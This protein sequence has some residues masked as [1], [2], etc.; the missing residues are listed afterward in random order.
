MIA[1]FEASCSALGLRNV[2]IE[3][4]AAKGVVEAAQTGS[5]QV[6]LARDGRVLNVP[7]GS[8]LLDVLHEAG[9]D[10]DAGCH[11]GIC[12]ACETRVLEGV[13]DHRDSI[14]SE[15]ERASGKTM[16]VCVSGCSGS[17]LVLDL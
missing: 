13:P 8:S 10:V 14:L 9:V 7:P 5:Y 16:L 3:R 15:S 11:E 2:H 4:F 6:V 17:R 12:G 1:A